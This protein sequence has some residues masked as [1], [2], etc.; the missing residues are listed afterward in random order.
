MRTAAFA[1]LFVVLAGGALLNRAETPLDQQG[2]WGYAFN[3]IGSP[4][5]W[6]C[7]RTVPG[8]IILGRLGSSGCSNACERAVRRRRCCVSYRSA[9]G[10]GRG[11]SVVP[12]VCGEAGC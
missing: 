3:G 5:L 7:L 6:F 2:K 8:V 11:S 12:E 1:A 9:Q 4:G 10:T